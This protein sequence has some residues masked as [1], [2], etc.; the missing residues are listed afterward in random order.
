MSQS[1]SE[2]VATIEG[3]RIQRGVT[4]GLSGTTIAIVAGIAA[5][6]VILILLF[7]K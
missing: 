6:A 7:K 4:T 5:V 3:D 2:S 1:S